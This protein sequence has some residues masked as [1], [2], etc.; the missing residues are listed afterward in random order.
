V[1]IIIAFFVV[2]GI[3]VSKSREKPTGAIPSLIYDPRVVIRIKPSASGT[4][5]SLA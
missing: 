1:K 5:D 4:F 2:V 3:V